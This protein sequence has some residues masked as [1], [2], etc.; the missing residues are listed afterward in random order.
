MSPL[1]ENLLLI[2]VGFFAGIINTLAG[3]GSL[4]TLPALIF[5][6][7]PPNVANGTN[8]IMI[9]IQSF[10]GTV[11]YQSKGVNTYPFS[12]YLGIAALLGAFLGAQI[13]VDIDALLFKRILAIIMIVVVTLI[14]VKP[15]SSTHNL[16]ERLTGKYLFFGIVGF[17]VIGIYGGFINAGVGFVIMIF[18]HQVNRMSLVRANAT[19]VA[20]VM[21]YSIGALALFAY[22]GKVDWVKG[23]WM[24]LG[25]SFGA[26]WTS[27]WSVAKGDRIIK[28]AMVVMVSIMAVK[29][30]FFD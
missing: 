13:A 16:T 21:I 4:F 11:G 20:L 1:Y 27:R 6:G 30:W 25:S 17:F 12:L 28:I 2:A 3:G 19:K 7:L 5:L 14:V 9:V 26:W 29:L 22:Y 23:L 10:F 24:A 18:L 15:K 8:R